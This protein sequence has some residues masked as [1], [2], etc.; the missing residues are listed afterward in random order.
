MRIVYQIKDG[1]PMTAGNLA[2]VFAQFAEDMPVFVNT[3]DFAVT[4]DEDGDG[5]YLDLLD[6][7]TLTQ[8]VKP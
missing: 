5:V 4:I 6:N 8:E 1:D 3:R 2:K 7:S